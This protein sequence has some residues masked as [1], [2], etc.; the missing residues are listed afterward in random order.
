MIRRPPRSTLFPYTTLFRSQFFSNQPRDRSSSTG[1]VHKC[2]CRI[3]RAC[4]KGGEGLLNQR[5]VDF[6]IKWVGCKG[7]KRKLIGFL[8]LKEAHEYNLFSLHRCY[9]SIWREGLAPAGSL[10]PLLFPLPNCVLNGA[11]RLT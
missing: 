9:G 4:R 10:L 5:T 11:Y 3:R 1:H 7:F 2:Q 8:R 6:C